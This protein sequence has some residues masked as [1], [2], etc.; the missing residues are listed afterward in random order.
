MNF[1]ILF[2]FLLTCHATYSNYLIETNPFILLGEGYSLYLGKE[3]KKF[4]FKAG[5]IDSE[6][7]DSLLIND[8][9]TVQR[10]TYSFT[11]DYFGKKPE[12]YFVG[13]GFSTFNEKF[14]LESSD[15]QNNNGTSLSA[16][17]GFRYTFFS[18]FYIQPRMTY[19]IHSHKNNN[20]KI[21]IN[22]EVYELPE[23]SF[24]TTIH[25]GFFF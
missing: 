3:I 19:S 20:D 24:R 1:K 25:L 4:R 22:S 18:N 11:I 10:Y 7:P 14:S 2:F 16:R 12:W 9:F 8:K 17:L 23:N 15:S 13:L 21:V 6:L 5:F